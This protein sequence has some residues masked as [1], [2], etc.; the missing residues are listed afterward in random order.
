MRLPDKQSGIR[1]S[2]FLIDGYCGESAVSNYAN[3]IKYASHLH[4][5]IFSACLHSEPSKELGDHVIQ[6]FKLVR[7]SRGTCSLAR[8][9]EYL[10]NQLYYKQTLKK[11]FE[12]RSNVSKL[13]DVIIHY[14]DITPPPVIPSR[15]S[16]V[17][18]HDLIYLTSKI[19]PENF[20]E[21]LFSR[22]F[23]RYV[24]DYKKF[25]KILSV[26]KTTKKDMLTEGFEGD[27]TVIYPPV[28]P[29]FRPLQTKKSILRK[30]LGLPID[31]N[32]IL[33]VS[34]ADRR[35]NLGAV[36]K[37]VSILGGNYKLVRVG[38]AIDNS[39]TFQHIDR[40]ILNK[41][42]NACDVLLLPSLAEGFGY[43]LAEAMATGLPVVA[44]Y[45]EVV[46]EVVGH[47]G[48][49]V[50][51][52]PQLLAQGVK[53]AMNDSEALIKRGLTIAK[54]YSIYEFSNHINRFYDSLL[55]ENSI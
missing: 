54:K 34:S 2:V 3:Q 14:T 9:S 40:K 21:W 19:K 31:K 50:S 22:N 23:S 16:T 18:V 41:I 12:N 11:Y 36:I 20:K 52:E 26:S 17:T 48:I 46:E 37:A 29:E 51:P 13:E 25:P 55:G 8:I 30:E 5:E 45:I 33:S 6:K 7:G 27:I 15:I 53:D 32:L 47:A 39:I 24:N 43:P 44:S 1:N 28:W 38:P 4:S 49:L 35:K 42:Y 10:L